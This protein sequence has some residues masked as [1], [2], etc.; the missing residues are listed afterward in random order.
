M[1]ETNLKADVVQYPKEIGRITIETIND[2]FNGKQVP[3]V[4]PV[5]VGIVDKESLQK[6]TK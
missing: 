1:N 2:Y 4:I 5:D 6:V 3:K